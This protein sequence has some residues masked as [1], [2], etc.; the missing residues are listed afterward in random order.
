MSRE[1]LQKILV[2]LGFNRPATEVYLFLL[3]GGP[4]NVN[5]I[6]EALGIHRQKLDRILKKLKDRGAV[7]YSPSYPTTYSAVIFEKV[8]DSFI[9]IRIGQRRT[10]KANKEELLSIWRSITKKTKFLSDN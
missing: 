4:Q 1:L 6:V 5:N 8:L 10:L 2:K 9:E 3:E 7:T